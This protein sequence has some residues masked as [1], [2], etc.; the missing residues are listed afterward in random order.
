M[1]IFFFVVSGMVGQSL[2]FELRISSFEEIPGICKWLNDSQ[3][4]YIKTWVE[5]EMPENDLSAQQ[6]HGS[7]KVATALAGGHLPPAKAVAAAPHV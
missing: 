1:G 6:F 4:T 5:K 2:S 3:Q 7:A